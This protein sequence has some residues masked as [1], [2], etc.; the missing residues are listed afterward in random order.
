MNE[1]A[2]ICL[3]YSRFL[4]SWICG[5][6]FSDLC[7]SA[8]SDLCF[9]S[10]FPNTRKY[11]PE[12]FLQCN[13]PPWKHFPFSEIS[14]S[15]KYV[16]SGKRF[17]AT[18]H[19][20]SYLLF[21]TIV[22]F[23]LAILF[24]HDFVDYFLGVSFIHYIYYHSYLAVLYSCRNN[25]N[26]Y[27]YCEHAICSTHSSHARTCLHWVGLTCAQPSLKRSPNKAS[28]NSLTSE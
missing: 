23:L 3:C 11:F 2:L 25:C 15:G 26:S 16:F 6:C 12:N 18:K 8:F 22:I 13:Q 9:P 20:L 1:P 5:L 21:S 28:S 24:C 17:T 10:S 7:Y 4:F 14:I 19:S 27:S